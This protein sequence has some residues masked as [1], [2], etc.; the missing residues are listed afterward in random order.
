M[1]PRVAVTGASGFCGRHVVRALQECG[2]SVVSV[3]RTAP[4][5]LTHRHWDAAGPLVP[6]LHGIDAVI[7]LAAAVGDSGHVA[8]FHAVNVDGTRRLLAAAADLP[9]VHVSSASVYSADVP[10]SNITEAH[11]VG[12]HGDAYSV[13]KLSGEQLALNSHKV[14]LRPHAVYGPGDPY[15]IPRLSRAVRASQLILPG[16]DVQLSLTAVE[17]LAEACV[18]AIDWP[19]G[20]YNI[21]DAAPYSRDEMVTSSL[22]AMGSPVTVRHAPVALLRTA[23]RLAELLQPSPMTTVYA[24]DQLAKD[25]TLSCDRAYHQGW[26]PTLQ[27]GDHLASLNH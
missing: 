26:R 27:A 6:N 22:I 7:H 18:A 23:A 3:G 21:C 13:T 12:G 14:V 9:V 20:P 24:V 4:V 11:P 2:M 8:E 25:F 10:R 15:L 1:A 19:A 5:G 16:P 17:N